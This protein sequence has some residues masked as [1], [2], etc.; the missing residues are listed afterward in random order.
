KILNEAKAI[1]P[2]HPRAIWTAHVS[3]MTDKE[4]RTFA[5]MPTEGSDNGTLLT[6]GSKPFGDGWNLGSYR[7]D[8]LE[9]ILETAAVGSGARR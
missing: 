7:V 2:N 4:V 9:K 1:R 6:I 3:V 8:G 5:V